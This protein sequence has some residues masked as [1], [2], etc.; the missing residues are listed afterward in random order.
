L[1]IPNLY[2]EHSTIS[3]SMPIKLFHVYHVR[4]PLKQKVTHAS[5][6]RVDTDTLLV[7]CQLTDGTTGW[8]EGLPRTYVTG[9]SID[10]A[11]QLATDS[12]LC[13]SL[14]A[15]DGS[16][17]DVVGQ[18]AEFQLPT[19]ISGERECFGNSVRCAFELAI[20]DAFSRSAGVSIAAAI[21]ALPEV[22]GL[23]ENKEQVRYSVPFTAMTFWQ[24][25][26]R[27]MKLRY[28]RVSAVKVKVGLPTIDDAR[29]LGRLRWMLGSNIDMRIDANEAWRA[30]ELRKRLDSLARFR[31][32]AVEQPVPHH[33]MEQLAGVKG[34]LPIP[35]MLDESLCSLVDAH[36]AVEQKT[37]D[38]FNIRLSKCGGLIPAIRLAAC[39]KEAGLGMQLGCQ[40]GETGILSAAGR[41]FATHI[42]GLRFVEGSYDRFLVAERLTIEDVT[43]GRGGYAPALT[44]PGLGVTIDEAAIARVTIREANPF[45]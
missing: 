34:Q 7:R 10:D 42:G 17:E 33:E 19:S 8:G 22:D 2:S 30:S 4:I 32:S 29:L 3:P 38:A 25:I 18:L 43:F 26:K 11:W 40:V 31:L 45:S 35:I 41:Q 44:S 37:C 5:F 23:W 28:Y 39:A 9:E 16:I 24:Q 36:R 20:L 15:I 21:H 14:S 6:S 13:R 1:T 12:S 27:A